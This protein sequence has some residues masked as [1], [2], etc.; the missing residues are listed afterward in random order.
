MAS[1]SDQV[2][3]MLT[4]ASSIREKE[5]PLRNSSNLKFEK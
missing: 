1:P 2:E 3:Y 5:F 4:I